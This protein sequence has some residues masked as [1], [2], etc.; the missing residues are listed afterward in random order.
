MIFQK[1]LLPPTFVLR[2]Q[3]EFISCLN[4]LL[5]QS[6]RAN[7]NTYTLKVETERS[8]EPSVNFYQNPRRHI[9][10]E[11]KFILKETQS[12]NM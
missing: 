1:K 12:N 10:D 11:N 2:R 5:S 9:K 3:N 6:A 7:N 4:I 8:Y